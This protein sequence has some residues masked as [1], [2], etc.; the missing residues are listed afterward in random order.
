M[1][2]SG[3]S[4]P[5]APVTTAPEQPQ[6]QK[7]EQKKQEAHPNLNAGNPGNDGGRPMK[8]DPKYADML[9]KYFDKPPN[10]EKE[11]THYK[12]DQV[13][14]VDYKKVANELPTLLGFAKHI[15]VD[16]DTLHRWAHARYKTEYAADNPK[17]PKPELW[18][19]L[20][21][22]KFYGAYMRAKEL[23]KWFLIEN[24]LN[25]LYNPQFAIFVAKNVTDMRDKVETDIDLT[26]KGEQIKQ[27]V[28]FNYIVPEKPAESNGSDN[29]E[30]QTNV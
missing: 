16:T 17:A 23:Q 22:P 2:N 15:G 4:T 27:V 13:T 14:W 30:H 28:G 1:D 11:L 21:R 9:I 7:P 12:G 25:G 24:G 8:Y 29:T 5:S 18:G 26:S 10:Y 20:K 6:E 19:Q 3:S